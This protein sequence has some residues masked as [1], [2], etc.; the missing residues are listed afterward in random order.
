MRSLPKFPSIETARP[1][2][3]LAIIQFYSLTV[4]FIKTLLN[5]SSQA[6]VISV[7]SWPFSTLNDC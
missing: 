5:S 4:K 2:I 6:E 1:I 3:T 7:V